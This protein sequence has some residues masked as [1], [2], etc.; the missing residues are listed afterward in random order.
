MQLTKKPAAIVCSMIVAVL[1]FLNGSARSLQPVDIIVKNPDK[2]FVRQGA[3]QC[4]PA[5]FYMVLKYY[6]DNL[7]FFP[8]Y[9][10]SNGSPVDLNSNAE[11]GGVLME[12]SPVSLWVKGKDNSTDWTRIISSIKNLYYR[13]KYGINE[14]YYS[15][16]ESNDSVT[17][18]DEK[19]NGIRNYNFIKRIVPGFLEQN[20]PVIIHLKRRWPFPGHYIVVIGY[21]PL[22]GYVSYMDPSGDGD[23]KICNVPLND[24][25]NKPWYRGKSTAWWGGA[26]WSGRWVGF[27]HAK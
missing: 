2:Y 21:D 23:K 22:S 18:L 13:N 6:G 4:G 27:Y 7:N 10:D 16:V 26:C 19:H 8:F 24:F 1:F 9:Y 3:G 20:R 17:G 15:V 25:L 11:K 14:R 12:N 5:S